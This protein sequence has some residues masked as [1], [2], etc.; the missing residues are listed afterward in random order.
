MDGYEL[1]AK[2]RQKRHLQHTLFIG[3]S[4]FKKR[5]AESG[6]DFDHFFNKPVD[7][8]ELF[9]LLDASAGAAQGATLC[10]VLEKLEPLRVLL[11]DDNAELA[12]AT[13]AFLRSQGLDV[14]IA[15][16]GREGLE[17]APDFKPQVTLCDLNLPDMSGLE[18]IRLL[19][20][21]PLSR[22]TYAVVLTA[23]SK[24]EIRELE[25]LA[26]G[27]GIDEFLSKPLTTEAVRTLV[28]KLR[29]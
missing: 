26:K 12:A 6:S 3:L 9:T 5:E 13:A 1:A 25:S 16:T 19:R 17:A 7:L 23:M 11:I 10:G 18:V 24:W 14:Q 21:N 22:Y 15:L 8:S 20:S 29:R 2:L 27:I 28:T 4:G